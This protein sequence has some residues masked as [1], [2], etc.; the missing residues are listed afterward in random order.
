MGLIRKEDLH[1][2]LL[3]SLSNP[4]LLINGDFK[5]NQRGKSSYTGVCTVD[6]WFL[7][8]DTN[9]Q[10]DVLDNGVRVTAKT[11]GTWT[12]FYTRLECMNLKHLNGQTLTLTF[13]LS[14]P[15]TK[16]NQL[17]ALYNYSGNN[18]YFFNHIVTGESV[19]IVSNTFTIDN[20]NSDGFIEFG[21]QLTN[22]A[23]DSIEIEWAKLE[24]GDHT[25][26]FVSRPYGEE[27]ALCQRYYERSNHI[28]RGLIGEGS[29]MRIS[30][31][32][33]Y[34]QTKRA[35]PTVKIRGKNNEEGC[36]VGKIG[37]DIN[38]PV[39]IY[40][41][42]VDGFGCLDISDSKGQSFVAGEVFEMH[43]WEADAE[44]YN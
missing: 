39:T 28:V 19:S 16:V 11:S 17:W 12:N 37:S 1:E 9:A 42:D 15:S 29:S 40:Q 27:L 41:N 24:I 26:Q 22:N 34:K 13:K 43:G 32:V 33:Q 23:G 30:I 20:I 44:M 14:K 4:N 6:R 36:V 5:I 2:S 18:I 8:S 7:S 21:I 25:T 3:N 38:F 10:L 35:I 31:D